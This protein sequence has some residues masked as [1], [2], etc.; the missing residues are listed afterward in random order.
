MPR[1]MDRLEEVAW[2]PEQRLP[3]KPAQ[4]RKLGQRSGV[5]PWLCS[6]MAGVSATVHGT[7]KLATQVLCSTTE[8]GTGQGVVKVDVNLQDEDIDQCSSSGWFAGTHRCNLTTMERIGAF[9]DVAYRLISPI[10]AYRSVY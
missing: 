10:L 6:T 8:V 2:A 3:L 5:V 1:G 4:C 7:K 9:T